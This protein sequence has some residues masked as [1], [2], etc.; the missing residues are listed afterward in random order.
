M[1]NSSKND[2]VLVRYPYSDCPVRRSERFRR[3]WAP[4]GEV[5]FQLLDG[6]SEDH[7]KRHEDGDADEDDIH[8][9]IR[10]RRRDHVAQALARSEELTDNY[11][12]YRSADR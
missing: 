6:Q 2:I 9:V 4:A 10:R 8:F 12:E 3:L 1:P 5:G 11:S 7:G